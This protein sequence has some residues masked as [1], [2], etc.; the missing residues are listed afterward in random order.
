MSSAAMEA[1]NL[2]TMLSQ[3]AQI[4]TGEEIIEEEAPF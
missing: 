2:Q 4:Q 1:K 3:G